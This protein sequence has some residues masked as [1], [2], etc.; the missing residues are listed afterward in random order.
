MLFGSTM[1]SWLDIETS[2]G[3]GLLE[4]DSDCSPSLE[5]RIL[6]SV[7]YKFL[8][9]GFGGG[10]AHL[11]GNADL[12]ELATTTLYGIITAELSVFYPITENVELAVGFGSEHLSAPFKSDTGWNVGTFT[13]NIAGSF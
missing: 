2:L 3:L 5:G 1:T 8:K 10:L 9:L 11:L 4:T 13:L 7:R 12:P 6:G